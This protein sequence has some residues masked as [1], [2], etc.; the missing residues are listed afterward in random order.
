MS[1]LKIFE[2]VLT[3]QCLRWQQVGC[4]D[5]AQKQWNLDTFIDEKEQAKPISS[6]VPVCQQLTHQERFRW[7]LPGI[8]RMYTTTSMR[9]WGHDRLDCLLSPRLSALPNLK[10]WIYC[11]AE[12]KQCN[13]SGFLLRLVSVIPNIC[14]WKKVKVDQSHT[15]THISYIY[16]YNIYMIEVQ[17]NV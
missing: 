7:L 3:F 5:Q 8:L 12:T 4:T 6:S 16:I 11:I 15:H 14:W 13:Y 10:L 17:A 9:E 1:L 2:P